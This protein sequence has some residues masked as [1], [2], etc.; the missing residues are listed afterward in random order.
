MRN[1]VTCWVFVGLSSFLTVACSQPSQP[2]AT[3]NSN[4]S[5]SSQPQTSAQPL[6]ASGFRVEW[7]NSQI[8]AGMLAAKEYVV[9][10]TLKNTSDTTWPA[11]G[12]GGGPV[13]MVLISYHWLPAQSDKPII[14]WDGVRN[15]LPKDIAPGE[16]FTQDKVHVITPKDPGSY[17]L[18]MTLVQEGV[19]W[20]EG[21]GANALIVPVTVQ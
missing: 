2:A 16:S 13:N 4:V 17:R 11:T 12:V 21:R 5:K 7:M 14:V 10:V 15:A 9:A 18:Q 1:R 19:S 6:P 3:S 20:F 8:P